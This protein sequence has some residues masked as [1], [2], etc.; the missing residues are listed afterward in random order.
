MTSNEARARGR[1]AR[2]V[3]KNYTAEERE[4]RRRLL[5]EVRKRRWPKKTA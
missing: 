5:A 2:G 3:P 4:R 1:M